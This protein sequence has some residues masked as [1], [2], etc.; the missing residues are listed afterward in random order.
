MHIHKFRSVMRNHT[1]LHNYVYITFDN[2]KCIYCI[3]LQWLVYYTFTCTRYVQCC[4]NAIKVYNKRTGELA[5]SY[6]VNQIK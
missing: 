2:C 6:H 3:A 1:T 4:V 5:V